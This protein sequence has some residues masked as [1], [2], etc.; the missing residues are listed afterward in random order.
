MYDA[1]QYAESAAEDA[2]M[3]NKEVAAPHNKDTFEMGV[4]EETNMIQNQ[5]LAG[6]NVEDISVVV[7]AEFPSHRGRQL[8]RQRGFGRVRV[9]SLLVFDGV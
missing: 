6:V 1:L 8:L 4:D 9:T 3:E 7:V 2:G 5:A